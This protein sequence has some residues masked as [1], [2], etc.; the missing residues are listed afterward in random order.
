MFFYFCFQSKPIRQYK[1]LELLEILKTKDDKTF[2]KFVK[3][4][5]DCDQSN[6]DG[7]VRPHVESFMYLVEGTESQ[8]TW[9][10]YCH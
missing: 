6:F 10:F 9:T 4:A 3:L 7:L 2:L 1:A 5:K 8:G